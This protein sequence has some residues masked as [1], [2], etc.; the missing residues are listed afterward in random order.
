MNI[1]YQEFKAIFFQSMQSVLNNTV[2]EI[3]DDVTFA[4]AGIDSLDRMNLLL[5]LEERLEMDLGEID[6]GELNT[7]EVLYQS[8]AQKTE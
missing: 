8:L 5:D 6:L 2:T 7:L 4:D 3:T 1:S